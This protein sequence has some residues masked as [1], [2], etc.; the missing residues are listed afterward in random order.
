MIQCKICKENIVKYEQDIGD[1]V[2]L[3]I[4]DESNYICDECSYLIAKQRISR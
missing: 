1:T 2:E 4:N 3:S